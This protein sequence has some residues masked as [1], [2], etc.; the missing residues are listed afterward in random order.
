MTLQEKIKKKAEG[1]GKLASVFLE[2][3]KFALE[4]QWISVDDDL[5]CNHEELMVKDE[6]SR[7]E[8][9]R[10]L[11]R[12]QETDTSFKRSYFADCMMSKWDGEESGFLWHLCSQGYITHWMPIP[13]LP[14]E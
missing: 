4:N 5:P 3:A 10:V 13:E 6:K 12:I 7:W 8:T 1:Y 9:K 14:K 2:G 11:V